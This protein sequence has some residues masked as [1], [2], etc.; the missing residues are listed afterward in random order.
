MLHN[1]SC[2]FILN[3][4]I[5]FPIRVV[6]EQVFPI[7]TI[8]LLTLYCMSGRALIVALFRMTPCNTTQI[9]HIFR[10]LAAI[11]EMNYTYISHRMADIHGLG[12][13][14]LQLATR[15]QP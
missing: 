12:E 13:W 10:G 8:R 14:L 5:M 3:M 7:I 11:V 15:H 1:Q 4:T 9:I 6:L 2:I